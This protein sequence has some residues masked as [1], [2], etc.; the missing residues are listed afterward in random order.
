MRA[1]LVNLLC[2]LGILAVWVV[3]TVAVVGR[4]AA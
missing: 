4:A 2:C 3:L 1:A